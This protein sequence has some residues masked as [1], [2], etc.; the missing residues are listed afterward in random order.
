MHELTVFNISIFCQASNFLHIAKFFKCKN[1]NHNTIIQHSGIIH[2]I[3]EQEK[4]DLSE[5][6]K[7]DFIHFYKY[8]N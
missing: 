4:Y 1:F 3:D 6:H 5:S 8:L 2:T 7:H